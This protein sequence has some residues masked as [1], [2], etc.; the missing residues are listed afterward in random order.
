M[1]KRDKIFFIS[2]NKENKLIGLY[3][4]YGKIIQTERTKSQNSIFP[5]FGVCR[6][7]RQNIIIRLSQE[8]D[9]Y[10]KKIK[11]LSERF[12]F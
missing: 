12:G 3:S 1:E 7:N 11:E 6:H 10:D 4:R 2:F 9:E 8:N 5:T